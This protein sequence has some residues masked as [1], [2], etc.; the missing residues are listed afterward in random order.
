MDQ[1]RNAYN[2]HFPS[3]INRS[4]VSETYQKQKPLLSQ[5][6]SECRVGRELS[7]W[8]ADPKNQYSLNVFR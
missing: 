5:G 3:Q 7:R 8:R 4:Y 2:S 6:L 1:N